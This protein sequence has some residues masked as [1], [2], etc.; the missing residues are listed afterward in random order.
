M[1]RVSVGVSPAFAVLE[2]HAAAPSL[3]DGDGHANVEGNR[4]GAAVDR[5]NR[6]LRIVVHVSTVNALTTS[7]R[8]TQL[9]EKTHASGGH[10]MPRRSAVPSASPLYSMR[11]SSCQA[12]FPSPACQANALCSA[13]FKPR[14]AQ[15][16]PESERLLGLRRVRLETPNNAEPKPSERLLGITPHDDRVTHRKRISRGD[17][18]LARAVGHVLVGHR[19]FGVGER[20]RAGGAEDLDEASAVRAV[21]WVAGALHAPPEEDRAVC[22]AQAHAP[23][24][25]GAGLQPHG[26]QWGR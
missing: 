9:A 18:Q 10:L 20:Q 8:E 1:R 14:Q 17:P 5:H 25:A 2:E 19:D 24:A 12:A 21:V 6:P 7:V 26:R 15:L 11:S 22:R 23:S 16:Q 4:V 3:F 13:T